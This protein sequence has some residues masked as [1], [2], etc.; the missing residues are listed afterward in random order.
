MNRCALAAM[1]ATVLPLPVAACSLCGGNLQQTPTFREEASGATARLIVYGALVD[2]Q[3]TATKLR[4]IQVLRDDPFR[5]GA[6]DITIPRFLP[7][8]DPKNPPRYLLFCDVYDNKLDVFRG[9]Q[10]RSTDGV[11]YVN[12][13]LKLD[14]KDAANRL[15]FFANY[16]EHPD[17]EI[18]ADAY[19]EFAKASD[20]E[21]GK[22]AHRLND[23]KLRVWL[24][25][26]Q[27]PAE[28]LSLYA[29]LL[30]ACGTDEDAKLLEGL[31]KERG[32]RANLTYDGA[33]SGYIA[34]R[35]REGWETAKRLLADGKAPLPLRLSVTRAMRL[36][37]GWQP[38]KARALVL[39]GARIM[40]DQG[41]LADIAVE[42]LRRM[43]IWDLSQQIVGL[44]GRKGYDS[45]IM[46]EALVRYALT[47]QDPP[48]KAFIAGVL[49]SDP[50]L[51]KQV[52][53]SLRFEK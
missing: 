36:H 53:E 14:P 44:F 5:G 45:P 49:R 32:E 37:F 50:M 48:S 31:L 41:E 24:K 29:F 1:M 40:I 18:A 25:D 42:D 22:V 2:A 21:I 51:V 52:E 9:V 27:T 15:V 8:S 11:D 38:D 3:V 26:P 17:K 35:P 43:R 39:D 10:I 47:C 28:R 19:L 7:I 13:V 34:L 20:A 23:S 30:G 4:I 46:K 33:M 16:L 6:T 12:K